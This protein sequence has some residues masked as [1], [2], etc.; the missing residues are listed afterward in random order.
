MS[1]V[2]RLLL[3]PLLVL[4]PLAPLRLMAGILTLTIPRGTT[5]VR[6]LATGC[7]TTERPRTLP[8]RRSGSCSAR[9]ATTSTSALVG[10]RLQLEGGRH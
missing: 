7:I 10:S 3:G 1:V 4:A 8:P 5:W 2:A 9:L 6:F